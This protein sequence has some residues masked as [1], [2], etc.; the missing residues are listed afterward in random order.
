MILPILKL[1]LLLP[2]QNQIILSDDIA[3]TW[4]FFDFAGIQDFTS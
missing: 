3:N 1:F 4:K 2:V